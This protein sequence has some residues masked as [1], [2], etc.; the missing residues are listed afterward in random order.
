[1]IFKF[2]KIILYLLNIKMNYEFNRLIS[3]LKDKV[4]LEPY[5]FDTKIYNL[6][7]ECQKYLSYDEL[8]KKIKITWDEKLLNKNYIECIGTN[9]FKLLIMPK[10]NDELVLTYNLPWTNDVIKNSV[11]IVDC[12]KIYKVGYINYDTV[13]IEMLLNIMLF[14]TK[15]KFIKE[16]IICDFYTGNFIIYKVN[17]YNLLIYNKNIYLNEFVF[18]CIYQYYYSDEKLSLE[19]EYLDVE[20][21]Y[22]ENQKMLEKEIEELKLELKNLEK[23]KTENDDAES[24]KEKIEKKVE[25]AE[26]DKE[27]VEKEKD[28]DAESDKVEID[29]SDEFDDDD[30]YIHACLLM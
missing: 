4:N 30:E 26:R 11:D 28:G 12:D 19:Q 9:L 21:Y 6:N 14:L 15:G 5:F 18:R 17:L 8:V 27:K 10:F 7:Y 3:Y 13:Y 25:D 16:I 2:F 29:I 23:D 24:E 1:M 20:K 22:V